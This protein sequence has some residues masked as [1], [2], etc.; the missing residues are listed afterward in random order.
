MA[1]QLVAV[2]AAALAFSGVSAGPCKPVS[3]LSLSSTA[4]FE[5]TTTATSHETLSSTITA[6]VTETTVTGAA[7]G[8]TATTDAID[9]TITESATDTA[10]TAGSLTTFLTTTTAEQSPEQSTTTTAG[11]VGPGPCLEE[12]ILYNPGFDDSNSNA[13]PWDLSSGVA[14]DTVQ[15][16]SPSNLLVSHITSDSPSTTFSQA[17]PAL[18]DNEYELVYYIAMGNNGYD[19]FDFRCYA[20]TYVNGKKIGD[21]SDFDANGPYTYQRANGVFTPQNPGDAGELRFE[22]QCEG[23]FRYA[24]MRVDDVSL[25][26]R[27]GA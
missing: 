21:S 27:C 7:T 3:S 8:T 15:P 12:Q 22:I 18:G 20:T 23:G 14:L 5:T 9:T 6:D 4:I 17:L 10:T 19:T 16:R 25:T 11:P 13:W 1:R 2:L 26:R 24:Y